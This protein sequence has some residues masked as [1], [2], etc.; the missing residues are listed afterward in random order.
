MSGP[1]RTATDLDVQHAVQAELG[2]APDIDEAGI[3]V[4]VEQG[5][6]TLSG[7]VDS[8]RERVAAVAAAQR[9]RGVV[10]VA[11]ELRVHPAGA[12][13]RGND[14]DIAAAIRRGLEWNPEVPETI[15][16]EVRDGKVLLTGECEWDFQRRTAARIVEHTHGVREVTNEVTLTERASAVDVSQHIRAALERSAV[17]DANS[18]TV[19]SSGNVIT[20]T[21]TVRSWSEREQAE[22]AAW[23]S[24]HV[25]EVRNRIAVHR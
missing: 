9:V 3:G 20:L 25:R 18:I 15:K 21:G 22:R 6:V 17:V 23:S 2:W 19:R 14:S 13:M 24:P 7:D 10:A 11:D 16:A 8:Y 5:T 4:A 1:T 12:L